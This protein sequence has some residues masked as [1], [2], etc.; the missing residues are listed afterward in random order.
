MR[1]LIARSRATRARSRSA[2]SACRRSFVWKT[3]PTMATPPTS[4]LSPTQRRT[5]I[6]SRPTIDVTISSAVTQATQVSTVSH[7]AS[8]VTTKKRIGNVSSQTAEASSSP[9]GVMHRAAIAAAVMT[10][11]RAAIWVLTRPSGPVARP[12]ANKTAAQPIP[13]HTGSDS[14]D[15]GRTQIAKNVT[16]PPTTKIRRCGSVLHVRRG[17][18]LP[19]T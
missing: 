3:L 17:G 1:S 7:G 9:A 6:A 4:A 18:G 13:A 5:S 16:N 2:S 12:A 14:I 15:E 8:G 11:A 19:S 10:A